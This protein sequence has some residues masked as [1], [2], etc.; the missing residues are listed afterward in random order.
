MSNLIPSL[1][2]YGVPV[3]WGFVAL[4]ASMGAVNCPGVFYTIVGLANLVING[5]CIYK[6]C[7][8]LNHEEK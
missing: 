1:K 8:N 3:V 5:Y 4:T 2:V 6:Y 7:K